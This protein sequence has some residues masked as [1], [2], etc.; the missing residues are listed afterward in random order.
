MGY[1]LHKGGDT[2]R[3]AGLE[4]RF[5][6]FKGLEATITELRNIN[7]TRRT[8]IE[9]RRSFFPVKLPFNVIS[10]HRRGAEYLVFLTSYFK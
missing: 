10:I 9:S 5:T 3:A 4:Q 7:G 1:I 2:M 8:I 6:D